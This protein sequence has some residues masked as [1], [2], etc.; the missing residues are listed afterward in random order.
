MLNQ[1]VV[2]LA[3][4]ESVLVVRPRRSGHAAVRVQQNTKA[5]HQQENQ[6][7]H[8]EADKSKSSPLFGISAKRWAAG[9]PWER[10]PR[11]KQ[12]IVQRG[13]IAHPPGMATTELAGCLEGG[14]Y[15]KIGQIG[16]AT[17]RSKSQP[18]NVWRTRTWM[19]I[20]TSGAIQTQ[21]GSRCS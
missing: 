21:P 3:P 19:Q 20:D 5:S 9:D 4:L 10:R 1:G 6:K 16:T 12:L 13:N 7:Q 14:V 15:G 18:S 8:Q 17:S 2:K 11:W